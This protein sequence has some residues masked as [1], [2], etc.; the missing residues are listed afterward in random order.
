MPIS[1]FDITLLAHVLPGNAGVIEG[2]LHPLLGPTH[3]LAMIA[4]GLLSAQIGGRAIWTVPLA[5][6]LLMGV[7]GFAGVAGGSTPIIEYG[8]AISV[9][10]I[11]LAMA[12]D[13][14]I[15]EGLALVAVGLFGI[16][17][18]YAHGEA[19]DVELTD[20]TL[21]AYVVGFMISTAG[22]HVIGALIGF[23]ALRQERGTT[24]LRVSGIIIGLIGVYFLVRLLTI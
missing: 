19:L 9:I 6:V 24:I 11:G 12:L 13:N 15:P 1:L 10:V 17:H 3:L 20:V 7:G 18:G 8:V 23:I 22:L 16:V 21:V 5:F 2:F 14:S 4:V